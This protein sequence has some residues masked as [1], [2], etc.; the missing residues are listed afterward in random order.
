MR[1]VTRTRTIARSPEQVWET[2]ADFG[3]ISAWAPKVDHSCLLRTSEHG[4]R[5]GSTRRIQIGRTTL[6]ERVVSWDEAKTL[7]YD[8]EGLPAVVRSVRYEWRLEPAGVAR[9]VVALT[10]SIDCGPR[11]PHDSRR[12][13]SISGAVRRCPTSAARPWTLSP[14]ARVRP[15]HDAPGHCPRGRR[16]RPQD[17][18]RPGFHSTHRVRSME[19]R[20]GQTS[21]AQHGGHRG[22][23]EGCVR[24]QRWICI[25]STSRP[26]WPTATSASDCGAGRRRNI[27]A[28]PTTRRRRVARSL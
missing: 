14:S 4:G 19:L 21:A 20:S 24:G 10:A 26:G 17:T 15:I 9:T 27:P 12:V 8:I 18:I 28:S 6:L 7:A 5:I 3:A 22:A 25:P 11:P 1:A 16:P 13:I 23:A 2:L